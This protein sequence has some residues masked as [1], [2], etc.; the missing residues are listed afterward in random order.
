MVCRCSWSNVKSH[1]RAEVKDLG[2]VYIQV[3]AVRDSS[4]EPIH[5]FLEFNTH[6]HTRRSDTNTPVL[7]NI[8]VT[9]KYRHGKQKH[10]FKTHTNTHQPGTRNTVKE[11]A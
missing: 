9:H 2:S 4:V 5:T 1:A 7:V 6:T 10:F 8:S 11:I 3:T